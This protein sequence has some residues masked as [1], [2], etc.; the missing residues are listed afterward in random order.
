M[1]QHLPLQKPGL[2]QNWW[3]QLARQ[4]AFKAVLTSPDA[5]SPDTFF[6]TGVREIEAAR[7]RVSSLGLEFAGERAFDFGCGLGRL[8]RALA[9]Y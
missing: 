3:D 4:N 8:S 1:A 2:H 9:R 6:A 7:N 5:D